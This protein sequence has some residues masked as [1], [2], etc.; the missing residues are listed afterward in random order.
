MNVIRRCGDVVIW[1]CHGTRGAS[2]ACRRHAD[3]PPRYSTHRTCGARTDFW[4]TIEIE[5]RIKAREETAR[6]KRAETAEECSV[7]SSQRRA[8]AWR[9]SQGGQVIE[10]Q[11][12]LSKT[13]ACPS[14]TTRFSTPPARCMLLPYKCSDVER[15]ATFGTSLLS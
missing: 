3:P 9:D 7:D 13:G 1:R 6:R 12:G 10:A 15:C 14:Y 11:A 2:R 8:K 5:D 4:E